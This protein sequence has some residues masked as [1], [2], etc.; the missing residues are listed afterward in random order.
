[1]RTT[2]TLNGS[3]LT[4]RR[5]RRRPVDPSGFCTRI[6]AIRGLTK[7]IAQACGLTGSAVSAWGR[8]P[9]KHAHAVARVTGVDVEKIRPDIY[10]LRVARKL[11]NGRGVAWQ[12]LLR[13]ILNQVGPE[14]VFDETYA[15]EREVDHKTNGFD[16]EAVASRLAA[17]TYE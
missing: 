15:F 3:G 16:H 6:H 13:A 2:S 8:V 17:T 1:M 10:D 4:T 5:Q 12:A 9:A 7:Q 11:A 14:A